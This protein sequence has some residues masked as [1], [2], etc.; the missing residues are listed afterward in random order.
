MRETMREFMALTEECARIRTDW[1]D[2][3]H[4]WCEYPSDE[5]FERCTSL[6]HDLT[7]ACATMHT[8]VGQRY[9]APSSAFARA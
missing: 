1:E 4:M 5:L 6:I 8:I 3:Y 9:D 2:A 7:V